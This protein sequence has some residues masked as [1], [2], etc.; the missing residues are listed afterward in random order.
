M[1]P[2]LAAAQM[3]LF[4]PWSSPTDPPIVVVPPPRAVAQDEDLGGL[5]AYLPTA[6]VAAE[7]FVRNEPKA[8]VQAR[9]NG[10]LRSMA[11]VATLDLANNWLEA[12]A[13]PSPLLWYAWCLLTGTAK[14]YAGANTAI[15]KRWMRAKYWDE[16]GSRYQRERTL[17]PLVTAQFAAMWGRMLRAQDIEEVIALAGAAAPDWAQ[18]VGLAHRQAADARAA[19]MKAVKNQDVRL[20]LHDWKPALIVPGVA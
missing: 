5:A 19:V 17:T 14:S 1:T 12:K 18:F 11:M 16:F 15:T 8:K 3:G 6:W 4:H 13:S 20:W 10:I 2:I 7:A 9:T